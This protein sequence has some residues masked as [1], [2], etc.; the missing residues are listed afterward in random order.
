MTASN[1]RGGIS[2]VS[3][4]RRHRV[5]TAAKISRR[6]SA[7]RIGGDG[8]SNGCRRHQSRRNG[9]KQASTEKSICQLAAA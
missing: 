1:Q 6:Q 4:Q 5:P 8:G 9:S 7:W 3:G 2:C